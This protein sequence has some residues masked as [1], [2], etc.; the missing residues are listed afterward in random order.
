[1][2]GVENMTKQMILNV[3]EERVIEL[4]C[5]V[6]DL[7]ETSEKKVVA[8]VEKI[9]VPMFFRT[10]DVLDISEEEKDRI[11]ALKE[12]IDTKAKAFEAVEGVN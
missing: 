7:T 2:E 8:V 6:L 5:E 11:K 1:M 12:V 4:M 10:I 9:G 3:N